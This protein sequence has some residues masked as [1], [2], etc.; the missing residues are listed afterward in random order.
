MN[1]PNYSH[2][3]NRADDNDSYEWQCE[4]QIGSRPGV[5][6]SLHK[7]VAEWV[8]EIQLFHDCFKGVK[9]T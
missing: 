4:T 6:I 5:I 7:G 9:W 2:R 8:T 3:Y 1:S